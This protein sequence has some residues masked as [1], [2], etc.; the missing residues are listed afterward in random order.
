M[1]RHKSL[2]AAMKER[3]RHTRC[4][5]SFLVRVF[6][7]HH[8]LLPHL[9]I[10]SSFLF[11]HLSWG[12]DVWS[13]H[14]MLYSAPPLL[15]LLSNTWTEEQDRQQGQREKKREW[16]QGD[17]R[18]AVGGWGDWERDW[19]DRRCRIRWHDC[20]VVCCN[21]FYSVCLSTY[22]FSCNGNVFTSSLRVK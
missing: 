17:D 3:G 2:W 10:F 1:W 15:L 7:S 21:L 5:L 8:P 19:L 22:L 16:K 12:C 9:P 4:M 20:A 13:C 11:F 18:G 14:L 6:C